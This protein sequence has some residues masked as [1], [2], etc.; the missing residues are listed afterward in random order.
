MNVMDALLDILATPG[1][2]NKQRADQLKAMRGKGQDRAIQ[3]FLELLAD[4]DAG[5]LDDLPAYLAEQAK[6]TR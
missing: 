4:E 2:T 1:I 6:R 5:K 3:S